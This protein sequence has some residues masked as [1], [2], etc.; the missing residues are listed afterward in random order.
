MKTRP[1]LFALPLIAIAWLAVAQK[2]ARPVDDNTLKNA[3]K[4][5]DEWLTYGRDYAETH[6]SPLKQIDAVNVKRLGLPGRGR[7]NPRRE[8]ALKPRP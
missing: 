5:P 2:A 3:A 7:P 1:I 8:P 4:N 6:Y